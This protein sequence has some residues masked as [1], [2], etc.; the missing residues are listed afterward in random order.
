M[1]SRIISVD[2]AKDVFEVAIANGRYQ[3]QQR[4]RL[5]RKQFSRFLATEPPS[6]VLMEACGGAHFWARQAKA[7]GHQTE[8]V[9]AQYVKPYRRR[10]KSDRI[11]TEALLE[12]HRC[13]GI[14]PVPVRSVEQQQI[15]QLHRVREQWK[16]TR[17]QRI[18]GLR[19]FLRELGYAIPEGAANAKKRARLIIDDDAIPVALKT[20]FTQM[21]DE[22]ASLEEAITALERQLKSMTRA[23]PDVQVLQQVSGIGL[24][25]STA[26]VACV[27][28]P[29]HFANGR[30]FAS[31]FGLTPREYSSGNTRYMGRISK[32]GDCYLR[33]LL[34]HGARSV[35]ARAKQRHK[36]G[37]PMN[38]LQRWAWQLEQRVGHNKATCALAN[39]L[40]RICWAVW[41]HQRD[42]DPNFASA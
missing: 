1:K 42:F 12:A 13:E 37:K 33:M 38:R 20:V 24:L 34:V 3:I 8:L 11:D 6:L 28:S 36:A 7:A 5:S 30:K 21:L 26:M 35:L 4:H 41:K 40:A 32:Q 15:Q 22:I 2:L 23:N 10:G 31:W 25:T 39:K 18:N 16:R 9:P 19:G 29:D 17:V 14:K 27:G